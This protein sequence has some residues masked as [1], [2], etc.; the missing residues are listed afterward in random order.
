MLVPVLLFQGVVVYSERDFYQ[1]L[2]VS[3]DA[4]TKEIKRAYRKLAMKYHPDKNPDNPSA[5][6]KFR[7][8]SDA[9]EVLTDEGK[10]KTY[11][12]YGEEGLK[13]NMNHDASD[14]FSSFFGGGGFGGFKF[15]FGGDDMHREKEI[16]RGAD[17]VMD[18]EVTL[19]EL[20]TGEFVEVARYKPVVK[21][22]SGKRKCNCRTEM[23]TVQLGPGS[24][25]MSPQQVCEQCPNV[26]LVN[27]EKVLEVE[28]EPGMKDGQE[29]PFVAEGEPHIDG[30]PGDL[31]FR[32]IQL[33]HPVFE[34]KGD[35]LY[36]NITISLLDALNGFTMELPHLDGHKVKIKQEKVTWPGARIRKKGEGMP[37]YENNNILG[38]LYI[39]F[40]VEFPKISLTDDDRKAVADILKQSSKQTP[41]N[42]L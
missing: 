37:N 25:Q 16:P 38:S 40:D 11:D 33:R 12:Q 39:T 7:D 29:Y 15:S 30:E 35:D 34:R 27:E 41:Y 36:T 2:G 24:F 23:K 18:L 9:Y 13:D 42:G 19:E 26:K 22:A 10:R 14:V 3:R 28:I 4:S 20:Y 17:I 5:E 8:I 31:K 32:M 1:I 6:E 21:P